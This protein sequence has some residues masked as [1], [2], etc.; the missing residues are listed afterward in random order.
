MQ[1]LVMVQPTSNN[2]QVTAILSVQQN[3]KCTGIG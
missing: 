3:G 2:L 1:I